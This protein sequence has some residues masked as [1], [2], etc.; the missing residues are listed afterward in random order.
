VHPEILSKQKLPD[1]KRNKA[2][3]DD[4]YD[5]INR[6]ERHLVRNGTLILKFFLNVSK[7]EQKRR[8]LERLEN[9]EKHWK[10]SLADLAERQH[11]DDYMTAFEDAINST[12]T[13]WA[14]WYIIPADH[15][16]VARALVAE[17]LITAIRKLH[18]TVPAVTAEQRRALAEARRQLMRE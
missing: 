3:W 1:G 6:F 16:W 11:W 14:P 15:K 10:F 9:E 8:F 5:D 18:L 12:S 17:V 7:E 4:R 13:K 2:F